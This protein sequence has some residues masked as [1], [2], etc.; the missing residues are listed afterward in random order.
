MIHAIVSVLLSHQTTKPAEGRWEAAI[1]KYE[2]RDKLSKPKEGGIVFVGSSS[3]VGWTTL[4]KDFPGKNVINRGFGGSHLSD[5]V[6][7]ANRIVTPYKP[8]M[9]I[10]F[11][12][13][14]D[15]ASGKSPETVAADF[16][17]FVTKVRREVPTTRIAYISISPTPLQWPKNDQVKAANSLIRTF[18]G[19]GENLVYID[20]YTSMLGP[21][22][23]PN[24]D[25]FKQDR[26]HLNPSG[27]AI[28]TKIVGPYLPW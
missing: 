5:S 10:L 17:A 4:A 20:V 16:Q 27:Y 26:L 24:P 19:H 8:K 12:G 22:G 14:N 3:I 21:D 2:A 6:Q 13:L 25:I 11:A 1:Q 15:I 23:T 7:Y 18:I 9:V 28:W